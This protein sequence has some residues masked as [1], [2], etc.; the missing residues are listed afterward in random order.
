MGH[1]RQSV[2]DSEGPPKGTPP[3][4]QDTGEKV[5]SDLVSLSLARGLAGEKALFNAV[6]DLDC[7]DAGI[8]K[9]RGSGGEKACMRDSA[10]A[11]V[12]IP[13]V[14]YTVEALGGGTDATGT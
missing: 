6:D 7:A 14:P 8:L 5:I 1:Y 13:E 10:G 3:H 4:Y 2:P 11:T 9:K 12:T